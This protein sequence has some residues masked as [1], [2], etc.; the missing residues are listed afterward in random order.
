M[1]DSI[2]VNFSFL[3]SR[4]VSIILS[5]GRLA[6]EPGGGFEWAS[7]KFAIAYVYTILYSSGRE[8]DWKIGLRREGIEERKR[9]RDKE[10]EKEKRGK[11]LQRKT[12]FIL[13]A[14]IMVT[15]VEE[16]ARVNAYM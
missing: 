4:N 1:E 16:N 8:I 7:W 5:P 6:F 12:L 11:N 15:V 3:E 14:V 13:F 2:F 9:N 10:N